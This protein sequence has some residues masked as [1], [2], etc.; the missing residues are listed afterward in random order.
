MRI[1]IDNN[2]LI[3]IENKEIKIDDLINFYGKTAEFV[4]SYI[5]IQELLE[6]QDKVENLKYKRFETIEKLTQNKYIRPIP[7]IDRKFDI[8]NE[9]PESV[10]QTVK[11]YYF[12]TN[13]IRQYANNFDLIDRKK[14][15]EIL[16]IDIKRINNFSEMEVID[17]F[18]NALSKNLEVNLQTIIDS[19]GILL[20]DQISSIFNL[21]DFIG[22]WKDKKSSKANMA[23]AYDASHAYFAAGCN[24]FLS[25]DLRARKKSKV[26][27]AIKGIET[28]IYEWKINKQ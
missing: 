20:H 13:E 18:N 12:L 11:K 10:F 4:Y 14:L 26:A 7:S 23:R 21:L 24:V 28:N 6:F 15:I 5:H 16:E 8:V 1:Y 3:S 22:F 25:N 17:Y 27:Y 9:H 2:I 19:M